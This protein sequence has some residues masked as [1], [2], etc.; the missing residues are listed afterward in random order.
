[1]SYLIIHQKLIKNIQSKIRLISFN[2]KYLKQYC[3][4]R[5]FRK[6]G[7]IIAC[8]YELWAIVKTEKQMTNGLHQKTD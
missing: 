7:L 3:L 6:K 1:M 5:K 4:T 8:I 2:S